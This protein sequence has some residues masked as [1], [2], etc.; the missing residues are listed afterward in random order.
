MCACGRPFYLKN[1]A[2]G[3]PDSLGPESRGVAHTVHF[4]KGRFN[5]KRPAT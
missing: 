1:E 2:T 3:L 5:A 4:F